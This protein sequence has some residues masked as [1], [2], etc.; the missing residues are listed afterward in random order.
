MNSYDDTNK[1][2]SSQF[3]WVYPYHVAKVKCR[4]DVLFPKIID[5]V[6]ALMCLPISYAT[7]ERLFSVMSVIKTKLLNRLAILIVGSIFRVWY[8][9]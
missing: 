2:L 4:N 6:L 8:S 1:Q 5:L 9:L 7:V 3:F